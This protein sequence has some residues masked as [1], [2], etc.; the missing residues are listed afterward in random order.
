ARVIIPD[1]ADPEQAYVAVCILLFP[2]GMMGLMLASMFSAAMSSLNSEFNV[3]A[4]VLTKDFY[5]RFLRPEADERHLMWVARA[6]TVGVGLAVTTGALFV[7]NLGGAFETN[8][9]F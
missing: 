6:T 5:Q 8:K 4:G 2:A 1:L 3:M 9:L 7:G